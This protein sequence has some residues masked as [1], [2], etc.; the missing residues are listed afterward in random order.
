[1]KFHA[2]QFIY[3]DAWDG[4]LIVCG[5][6]PETPGAQKIIVKIPE[7][8]NGIVVTRIAKEAFEQAPIQF[9]E[10]PKTLT[11][12]EE[13][14][15]YDCVHLEDV[16][17]LSPDLTLEQDVFCGCEKMTCFSTA[18]TLELLGRDV[19]AFCESLKMLE[20]N[21]IGDIPIDCFWG[22]ENL[23]EFNFINIDKVREGAFEKCSFDKVRIAQDFQYSDDFLK[24]FKDAKIECHPQSNFLNLAYEGYQV[25]VL[26]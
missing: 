4:S 6:A 11:R 25:S 21:I 10:I 22:C 8:V 19:F 15:F 1:M 3:E 20:A 26:L 16:K 12:I 7:K 13:G 18:S 9:L 23:K 24:A 17:C 14:A 5:F 2:G